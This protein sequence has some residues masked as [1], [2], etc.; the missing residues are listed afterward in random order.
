VSAGEW[1]YLY[2]DEDGDHASFP[3]GIR[4][5]REFHKNHHL[6]V[7]FEERWA[8]IGPEI[9]AAALAEKREKARAAAEA[10]ARQAAA[11]A[12]RAE[13]ERLQRQ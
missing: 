1:L 7:E 13:R 6:F 10:D 8:R 9:R 12:E 3:T 5:P 4:L 2:L 11:V